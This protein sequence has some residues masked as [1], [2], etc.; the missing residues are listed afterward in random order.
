MIMTIT[1]KITLDYNST[2]CRMLPLESKSNFMMLVGAARPQNIF[3]KAWE[4]GEN[5]IM[6]LIN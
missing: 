2:I 6:T 3:G 5:G 1:V 4:S